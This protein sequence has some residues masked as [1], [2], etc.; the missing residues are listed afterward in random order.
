MVSGIDH[1]KERRPLTLSSELVELWD[2]G[3]TFYATDF[4]SLWD[5]GIIL[6]GIA[7]FITRMI[8]LIGGNAFATDVAFDIL[9]VEALFLVPR[10]VQISSS[11]IRS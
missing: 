2:A 4:W 7:F 11:A 9:S 1:H 8:G 6:T 5:I 10:L 3:F